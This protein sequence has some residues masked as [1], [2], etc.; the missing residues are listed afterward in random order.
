M[1]CWF[2]LPGRRPG[3]EHTCDEA[4][5]P[6]SSL[7]FSGMVSCQKGS[8]HAPPRSPTSSHS[9]TLSPHLVSPAFGHNRNSVSHPLGTIT[10]LKWVR[11]LYMFLDC[12]PGAR[13]TPPTITK[14]PVMF[15]H[16][17]KKNMKFHT[18]FPQ[19]LSIPRSIFSYK[20]FIR[21]RFPFLIFL[22]SPVAELLRCSSNKKQVEI[23][24]HN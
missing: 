10:Q 14:C 9:P 19:R 11:I 2:R 17:V 22:K 1:W 24:L 23:F 18:K 15:L 21:D 7:G 4:G 5:D 13:A 3:Q 12:A 8:L 6:W 16:L 20:N